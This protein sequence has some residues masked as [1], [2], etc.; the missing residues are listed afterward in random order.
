MA[1]QEKVRKAL[2]DAFV[3]EWGQL[4][5]HGSKNAKLLEILID[6]AISAWEHP[7]NCFDAWG[8]VFINASNTLEDEK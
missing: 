2:E 1:T 7:K 8:T 6:H 3:N 4:P 5:R